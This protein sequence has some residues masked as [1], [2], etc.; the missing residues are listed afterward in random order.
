MLDHVRWLVCL[1]LVTGGCDVIFTLKDPP[2]VDVLPPAA[3]ADSCVE[4]MTTL[5]FV[6]P[7]TLDNESTATAKDDH[8][9]D[10]C[11]GT[12][13]DSP[14]LVYQV[15]VQ[16]LHRLLATVTPD[17][18]YNPTVVV[19]SSCD[20]RLVLA[21]EDTSED[22]GEGFPETVVFDN[23]R[24]AV[25]SAFVVVDAYNGLPGGSYRIDLQTTPL[26][27][28]DVCANALSNITGGDTTGLGNQYEG[29]NGVG[30]DAPD[31][32]VAV[33]VPTGTFQVSV[34]PFGFDIGL[35][36]IA[37]EDLCVRRPTCLA[38]VDAVDV[39]FQETLVYTN[40]GSPF[41][42]YLVIDGTSVS[43]EGQF[44]ITF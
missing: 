28:G 5:P 26:P 12:R 19:A 37:S 33:A 4:A 22:G 18:S 25:S 15:E 14:D 1:V 27:P 9:L 35:Y 6:P 17:D 31:L 23:T 8:D 29:C 2:P 16:P 11:I 40:P 41:T 32:V 30:S 13:T 7:V 3:V 10:M 42:G 21:C 44:D 24:D 39:D 43:Q 36:L 20:L 34:N 38:A